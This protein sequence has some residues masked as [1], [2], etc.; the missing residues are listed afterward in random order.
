MFRC[1][2]IKARYNG[3]VVESFPFYVA[4]ADASTLG[5]HLFRML[6]FKLIDPSNQVIVPVPVHNMKISLEQFFKLLNVSEKFKY[7][8]HKPMIDF[9]VK[10][11]RKPYRA[12]P[13]AI[14]DAVAKELFR[15]EI[16]GLIEKIDASQRVSNLVIAKKKDCNIRLHRGLGNVNKA[17]ILAAI[18]YQYLRKFQL[19]CMVLS[20]FSKLDIRWGY[21]QVL[22]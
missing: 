20:I 22:L 8:E 16:E 6:D 2:N 17:I 15:I 18:R 13:L 7:L 10:L 19:N 14:R 1:C 4:K 12:V 11:V 9:N 21:L 3:E 5:I